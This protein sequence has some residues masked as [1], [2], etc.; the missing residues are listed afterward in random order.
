[1]IK[2]SHNKCSEWLWLRD[3]GKYLW[4]VTFNSDLHEMSKHA[5][6]GTQ[7][8]DVS[9]QLAFSEKDHRKVWGYRKVVGSQG[10]QM[11][12]KEQNPGLREFFE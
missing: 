6:L 12:C 8:L 11:P 5:I 4:G 10:C 7:L 3:Q 1:M 9:V 2:M